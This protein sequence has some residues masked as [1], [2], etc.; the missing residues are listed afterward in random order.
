LKVGIVS[1]SNHTSE[2]ATE[3]EPIHHKF[4][5]MLMDRCPNLEE[6]AIDGVSPVPLNAG[7]LLDGRWPNLRRLSL[8]DMI[9]DWP[10]RSTTEKCPFTTFLEAHPM[11][12]SL[13]ISR[14][15]VDPVHLASLNP[16]ALQLTSFSGTLQ[17]LQALPYLHPYLKSVS[18]REAMPTREISALTVASV[19]QGLTSLTKLKISFVLHSMYDSGNLLRTLVSNCPQL[20]H[21]ELTCGHK[22][23]FQLVLVYC[24]PFLDSDCIS[25][26]FLEGNSWLS[27]ASHLASHHC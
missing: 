1:L 25:G 6:L 19:L 15:N 22:P 20:R 27:E 12:K 26:H 16:D 4:R 9:L 2:N 13:S 14:R 17:Q 24:L 11:L 5:K 3:D 10:H 8:G 21:L 7:S 23:S 18:F